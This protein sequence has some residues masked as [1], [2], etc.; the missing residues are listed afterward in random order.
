MS[1][2]LIFIDWAM[3]LPSSLEL[4]CR[5]AIRVLEEELHVN[6]VKSFER[7]GMQKGEGEFLIR[8]LECK[9]ETIPGRYKK[10][11]E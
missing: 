5:E 8:L 1:I 6:Y 2:I 4:E 11:I 9:F 7:I 3:A 10:Q